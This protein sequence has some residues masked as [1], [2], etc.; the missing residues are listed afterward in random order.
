MASA[1]GKEPHT[2]K[3][4]SEDSNRRF[5]SRRRGRPGEQPASQFPDLRPASP[6]QL[7]LIG[8]A[9]CVAG[10]LVPALGVLTLGGLALLLVAGLSLLVRPRTRETYWRGRQIELAGAPTWG[11]RFYR[12]LYRR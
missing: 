6:G 3:K 2:M 7:A 1:T 12:L 10:M 9:L 5:A 11:E 4:P 8:G